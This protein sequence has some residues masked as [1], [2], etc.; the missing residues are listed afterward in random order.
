MVN[1]V[2]FF[3]RIYYWKG[4]PMVRMER[5][6]HGA[7]GFTLVELLVVI[8]II[9]ILIALLLPAVQAVR[10][11]ARRLECQNHLKQLGLA[12]LLHEQ[13]HGFYPS[14]GWGRDWLGVPEQGY[15][16]TQPGSWAYNVLEYIEQGE[17]RSMGDGVV[18]ANRWQAGNALLEMGVGTFSCPS[19]RTPKPLPYMHAQVPIPMDLYH[20]TRAK[21]MVTRSDYAA[22]AGDTLNTSY[23]MPARGRSATA[24]IPTGCGPTRR[25]VM[26][27]PTST[28]K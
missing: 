12:F 22:C 5:D 14:C 15:G 19:R 27:F 25:T 4:C 9:G 6:F 3:V 26:E 16:K 28:A 21:T 11:A 7:R 17:L 24:M 20:V 10:E 8:A 1:A 23:G 2:G 18:G 13:T